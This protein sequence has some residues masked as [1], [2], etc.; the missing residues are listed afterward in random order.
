MA[1]LPFTVSAAPATGWFVLMA[2]PPLARTRNW[3]GPVD[4]KL[5]N[6]ESAQMKV[7]SSPFA[8]PVAAASRT[9]ARVP[10]ANERS[11]P[12]ALMYPPGTMPR[13]PRAV[14][15]SPPATVEKYAAALFQ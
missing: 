9:Q 1:T 3:L 6:V 11:P 10:A 2:T 15:P 12:A 5:E 8:S 13:E 4:W 14:F 7:P